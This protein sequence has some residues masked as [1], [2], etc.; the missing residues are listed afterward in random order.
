MTPALIVEV[1]GGNGVTVAKT[2]MLFP[3]ACSALVDLPPAGWSRSHYLNALFPRDLKDLPFDS[4]LE[5]SDLTPGFTI[6]EPGTFLRGAMTN[7]GAI[8]ARSFCA[9]DRSLV[10]VKTSVDLPV[11]G[12]LV[13]ARVVVRAQ[14]GHRAFAA[15]C[16][17]INLECRA[18][19]QLRE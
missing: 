8:N 10:G 13:G 11:I 4:R 18:L 15:N 9:R 14:C 19:K 16:I 12:I 2:A 7:S 6:C 1:G 3:N 5:Y 17:S